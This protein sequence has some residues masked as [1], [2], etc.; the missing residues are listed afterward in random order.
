MVGVKGGGQTKKR[1]IEEQ[2][3]QDKEDQ[4]GGN[5]HRGNGNPAGQIPKWNG[6]GKEIWKHK[7]R[8]G[9]QSKYVDK[10]EGTINGNEG[11]Q[12]RLR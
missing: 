1:G 2:G 6:K 8:A 5:K 3:D 10:T 4:A 7:G 11:T 9:E 12:W